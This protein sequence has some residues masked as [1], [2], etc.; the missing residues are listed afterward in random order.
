MKKYLVFCPEKDKEMKFG[1]AMGYEWVEANEDQSLNKITIVR[2]KDNSDPYFAKDPV[3]MVHK[4]TENPTDE[5][6]CEPYFTR[7]VLPYS[8]VLISKFP[9]LFT[10]NL[11]KLSKSETLPLFDLYCSNSTMRRLEEESVLSGAQPSTPDFYFLWRAG[12]VTDMARRLLKGNTFLLFQEKLFFEKEKHSKPFEE[13]GGSIDSEDDMKEVFFDII[14]F[15]SRFQ[16][17]KKR[18][19]N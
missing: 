7:I 11:Q 3:S 12:F 4:D 18:N 19:S 2:S 5:I 15:L 14:K 1:M 13:F 17:N 8:P 9:I 10:E 16:E 6:L